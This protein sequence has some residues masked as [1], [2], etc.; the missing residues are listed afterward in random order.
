MRPPLCETQFSSADCAEGSLKYARCVCFLAS[1]LRLM[2]VLPPSSMMLPAWH[3]GPVPPPHSSVMMI[4]LPSLLNPAV[5]R[6]WKLLVSVRADRRTGFS[7]VEILTMLEW[8]ERAAAGRRI[9]GSAVTSW[10]FRGPVLTGMPPG[11]A[12]PPGAGARGG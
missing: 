9:A 5:C 2:I 4:F 8:L 11:L 10:Q 12:A 6:P 7:G 1:G 3:I